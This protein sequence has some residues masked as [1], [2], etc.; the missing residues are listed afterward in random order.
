MKHL[1]AAQASVFACVYVL[2]PVARSPM[3][4]YSEVEPP[5]CSLPEPYLRSGFLEFLVG[6]INIV[7]WM[8][9]VQNALCPSIPF[10]PRL[11]ASGSR[12][13]Q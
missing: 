10:N 9:G 6:F 11:A 7:M 12:R 2:M 5:V 1:P 13:G 8:P 3:A 4:R